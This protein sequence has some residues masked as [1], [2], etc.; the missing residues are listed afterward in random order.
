MIDAL[1]E[2]LHQMQ[3]ELALLPGFFRA[4]ITQQ[5]VLIIMDSRDLKE[6][7]NTN[8]GSKSFQINGVHFIGR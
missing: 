4:D 7:F 3:K 2:K 1:T 6:V 8:Y 5:G